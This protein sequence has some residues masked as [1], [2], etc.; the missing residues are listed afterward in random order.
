MVIAHRSWS[1]QA[2]STYRK[3][4]EKPSSRNPCRFTSAI[5]RA[6]PGCT[7]ASTVQPHGRTRSGRRCRARRPSVPS[8]RRGRTAVSERGA[9]QEPRTMS[10]MFSGP[11]I[12]SSARSQNTRPILAGLSV[13]RSTYAANASASCGALIHGGAG[14]PLRPTR[15]R[16]RQRRRAS[17]GGGRCCASLGETVGPAAAAEPCSSA[18]EGRRLRTGS[19]DERIGSSQVVAAA[20]SAGVGPPDHVAGSRGLVWPHLGHGCSRGRPTRRQY[21]I[22]RPGVH[23][24]AREFAGRR[25]S[26]LAPS[27]WLTGSEEEPGTASAPWLSDWGRHDRGRGRS[28]DAQRRS[29]EDYRQVWSDVLARLA[30]WSEPLVSLGRR[31]APG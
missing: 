17:P 21:R 7:L 29:G 27:A 19:R 11:A 1:R 15:P 18:T 2:P 4:G 28:R 26:E 16:T 31:R 8:R 3:S 10:P 22:V 6:L 5:E 25:A 12:R 30:T 9:A 14:S 20:S 13:T 23:R 24:R